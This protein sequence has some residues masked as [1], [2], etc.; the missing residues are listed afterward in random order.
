METAKVNYP[1]AKC[2][3]CLHLNSEHTG[4]GNCLAMIPAG[5]EGVRWSCAC[6]GF[7]PAESDLD[8]V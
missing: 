5:N 8:I 2:R 3:N 7:Q 4:F 6:A 1:D